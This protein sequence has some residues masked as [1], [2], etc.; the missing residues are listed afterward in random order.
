VPKEKTYAIKVQV[1]EWT[2]VIEAP[3][4]V[5]DVPQEPPR[6]LTVT[7]RPSKPVYNNLPIKPKPKRGPARRRKIETR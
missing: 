3:F 1:R 6:T 7:V 5:S 2:H 4:Y